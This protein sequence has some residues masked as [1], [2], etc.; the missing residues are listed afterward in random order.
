MSSDQRTL[1]KPYKQHRP[2]RFRGFSTNVRETLSFVS[3]SLRAVYGKDLIHNAVDVSHDV[4]QAKNDVQL[5]FGDLDRD[6]AGTS[7]DPMRSAKVK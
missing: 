7:A 4:Q 2:G 3:L 1:P 5:I 6:E